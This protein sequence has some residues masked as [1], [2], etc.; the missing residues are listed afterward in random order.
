MKKKKI[1][2]VIGK[3]VGGGL[4]SVILDVL[5]N[6]EIQN[7]F[8]VD[9]IID[10]DSTLV[11]ISEIEQIGNVRIVFLPPYQKMFSYVHELNNL[12]KKNHYDIIHAHMSAIN[13]LPMFVAKRR[14]VKIRISQSHNLVSK[15]DGFLKN[16]LKKFLA[17]FA[18][19]FPNEFAA[20]TPETG[21]WIFGSKPVK[22]LEN[23]INL[24]KYLFSQD[25]RMQIRS[26]LNIGKSDVLIGNF[27]RFVGYKNHKFILEILT[28]LK[29]LGKPMKFL[30]VGDGPGKEYFKSQLMKLNLTDNVI[31]LQAVTDI[32]RYYSA[33]DLY[34]FPSTAEAFGLV[35]VEAQ[36]NGLRVL[37]SEGVSRSTDIGENR[38]IRVPLNDLS[39]WVKI[40]GNTVNRD[41]ITN[42]DGQYMSENVKKFSKYNMGLRY[43][44]YY[45]ELLEKYS[46]ENDE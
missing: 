29:R 2:I 12:M 10:N 22:I 6:R 9:L 41:K 18:T 32:Q 46:E 33:L 39:K 35:S 40:I 19:A 11:P 21:E 43:F 42:A 36:V 8:D 34:V 3:M 31:I 4:E 38:L 7:T 15:G 24:D 1:G 13:F 17:G 28:E 27:S 37:S 30:L 20:A 25:N 44:N 45:E 5:E 23:G 14:G 26:Q 16:I